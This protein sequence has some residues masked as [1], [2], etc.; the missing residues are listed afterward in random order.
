MVTKDYSTIMTR[1][2]GGRWHGVLQYAANII[3]NNNPNVR[4]KLH[5][6]TRISTNNSSTLHAI[7]LKK[8]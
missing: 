8:L 6:R 7:V 1:L 4:V 3:Y 5:Q 2:L